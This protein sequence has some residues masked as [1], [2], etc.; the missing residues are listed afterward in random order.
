[1]LYT[2]EIQTFVNMHKYIGWLSCVWLIIYTCSAVGWTGVPFLH[3]NPETKNEETKKFY[4]F[5]IN[6]TWQARVN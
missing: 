5:F 3:F 2:S 6:Q 1:M 4:H